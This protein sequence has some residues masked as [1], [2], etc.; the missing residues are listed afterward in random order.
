MASWRGMLGFAV[1]ALFY[2][3][4]V[5]SAAA[6]AVVADLPIP[7]GGTERA[8]F[9]AAPQGRATVVLLA[10]GEGIVPIDNAGNTGNQNFLIRTR[11][12]WQQ[13]GINAVILA[14]PN[15]S[16]LMG[17][18]AQPS[19]AAALGVAADFARSRANV[20]VWLV[21]TSM[22]SIAAV[23]GGA[24]LGGKVAGIILTSSVT[25]PGRAGETAF[26][27]GASSVA[28]PAL[29]ISNT[30][31]TCRFS[32]PSDGQNLVNAMASSPRKELILVSSNAIQGD[33]CEARSPH[34]Y[35]GI[36]ASVVQRMGN[37]INAAPGR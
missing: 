26:S 9:L 6:Q 17:Q 16:S 27:A 8:A 34:G 11:T 35:L 24:R 2:V 10:G 13:Y 19:Y 4:T 18:R 7:S 30:G 21:G 32:P 29:V 5:A 23:N 37:W 33:P 28:V 3:A 14:S 31:D 22:G 12:M 36:E 15:G 1:V 25:Q 20:P